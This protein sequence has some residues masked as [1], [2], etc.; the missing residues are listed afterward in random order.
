M[1]NKNDSMPSAP[2]R[3]MHPA[4]YAFLIMPFDSVTDESPLLFYAERAVLVSLWYRTGKLNFRRDATK[5]QVIEAINDEVAYISPEFLFAATGLLRPSEL[6]A[7]IWEDATKQE[8]I[9]CRLRD[10]VTSC[11]SSVLV[12]PSQY[13]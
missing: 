2:C 10:A 1:Q 7:R 11:T 9:L 13:Q 6:A 12:F 8:E 4:L 5:A 3:K